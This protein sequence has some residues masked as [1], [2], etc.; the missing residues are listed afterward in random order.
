MRNAPVPEASRSQ[1]EEP[2]LESAVIS[3]HSRRSW[4]QGSAAILA[5]LF[6]GSHFSGSYLLAQEAPLRSALESMSPVT[7]SH[8]GDKMAEPVA[9]LVNVI[10]DDSKPL[11]SL[12]L[13]SI[14]MATRFSAD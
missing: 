9:A 11:R 2:A 14:E 7:G 13:G 8:L 3:S 10:L 12:Q 1:K 6:S 5:A 4:V